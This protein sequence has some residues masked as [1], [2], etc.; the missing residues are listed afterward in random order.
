MIMRSVMAVKLHGICVTQCELFYAG[1]IILPPSVLTSS[2]LLPGDAV[3]VYNFN[4]GAR[5]DTYVIAG[6]DDYTVGINGPSARLCYK[7][8]RIVVVQYVMT[9]EEIEPQVLF[10]NA[11]NQQVDDALVF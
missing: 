6:E 9:D 3:S 4:N 11:E 2:K 7:G 5:Y 10:F 8:D 1:S